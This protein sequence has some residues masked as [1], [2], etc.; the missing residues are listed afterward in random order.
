MSCAFALYAGKIVVV[1]NIAKKNPA[2]VA[3]QP[4]QIYLN[5][6]LERGGLLVRR[7]TII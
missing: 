3:A 2:I 6:I 4:A 5:V 1:I 7:P